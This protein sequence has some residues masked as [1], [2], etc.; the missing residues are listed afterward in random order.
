MS[1]SSGKYHFQRASAR[2]EGNAC[3]TKQQRE[4]LTAEMRT[5]LSWSSLLVVCSF[6]LDEMSIVRHLDF[7]GKR[8]LGYVDVG[9][10]VDD[11]SL[12]EATDAFSLS[13]RVSVRKLES[14]NCL[15]F[16]SRTIVW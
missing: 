13:C 7:N 8:V 5:I 11:D 15:L 6:V 9:T 4:A 1:C 10:H 14:A 16:D 3:A 2:P 12:P